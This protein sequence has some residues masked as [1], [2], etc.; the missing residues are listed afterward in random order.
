MFKA[1]SGLLI[2]GISLPNDAVKYNS[3]DDYIAMLDSY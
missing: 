3:I 2:D 1:N